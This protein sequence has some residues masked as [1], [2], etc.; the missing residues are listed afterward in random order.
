MRLDEIQDHLR[1]RPFQ[2]IRVFIPDGSHYDVRHPEMAWLTRRTLH[3]GLDPGPEGIP[4]RSA[5]CDPV[6][7]TRIEPIDGNSGRQP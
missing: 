4:D 6:H 7:I 2:A 5:Y 3:I 1:K